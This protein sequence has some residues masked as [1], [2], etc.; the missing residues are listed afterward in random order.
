M[1]RR[2]AGTPL[3]G[4]TRRHDGVVARVREHGGDQGPRGRDREGP[5]LDGVGRQGQVLSRFHRFRSEGRDDMTELWRGFANMAATK[6]REVVIAKG[7]GSTVWDDK[8]KSYLDS[9]ASDL[10]DETT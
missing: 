2:S 7:R 10:K 6:G 4:R 5:R 8:G 1:P 3:R 9:T